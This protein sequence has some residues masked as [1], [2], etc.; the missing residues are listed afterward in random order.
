MD[1]YKGGCNCGAVRFEL[2]A[3]P[4]WISACHCATCRKRT[5]SDYGISVVVDESGIKEFSGETKTHTRT[6][7]SGNP[8]HYEF[9]T[10]CGTTV[11]WHLTLI[12]GRQVLAAG[13]FDDMSWMEILGEMYTSEAA[14]W[15]PVGCDA[16]RPGAPDD[17]WRTAMLEQ[18]KI[19]FG[20]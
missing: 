16:A 6:G 12:P 13:A 15:G 10:E 9:C 18:A 5:G 4:I 8:V 14:P 2:G 7:D 17:D 19:R 1:Q 11:R 3:P 20:G